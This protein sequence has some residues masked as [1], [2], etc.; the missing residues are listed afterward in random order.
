MIAIALI[1]FCFGGNHPLS[2]VKNAS[3]AISGPHLPYQSKMS[4]L[5]LTTIWKNFC[6]NID[7]YMVVKICS[8]K[9]FEQRIMY[10]LANKP[11][12]FTL[13]IVDNTYCQ[14]DDDVYQSQR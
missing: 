2:Y 4:Q 14:C 7:R 8:L 6:Q 5:N 3:F 1:H 10:L 11:T 9:Y 12:L 13:G